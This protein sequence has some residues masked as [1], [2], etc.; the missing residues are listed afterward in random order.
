MKSI[1]LICP[2]RNA[3]R[4]QKEAIQDYIARL[5]QSGDKVHYPARDTDQS[6]DGVNI[7][8]TNRRAIEQSDEVHIFYDPDSAGSLFDIG[9]AFALRKKLVI[10]NVV[11]RTEGKSFSNVLL[12]WSSENWID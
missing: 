6:G 4:E 8:K 9:I 11:D 3:T 5:E 7:C 12:W 10:A 2:V 1:F